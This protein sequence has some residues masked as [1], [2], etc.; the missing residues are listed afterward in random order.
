MLYRTLLIGLGGTGIDVLRKFKNHYVKFY[1]RDQKYIRLLGI[2]T[3]EQMDSGDEMLSQQEFL[4]LGNPRISAKMVLEHRN[5]PSFD[6]LDPELPAFTIASGAGMKRL[7]GHIAYFWRGTD[8]VQRLGEVKKKLYSP[9]LAKE[10]AGIE[11]GGRTRVFI[12][13]SVCGGTGTSMFLNV[14]YLVGQIFGLNAVR[15]GVLFLPSTFTQLQTNPSTFRWMQ[16]NGYAALQELNY[17]M[18]NT[19]DAKRL[20]A[21]GLNPDCEID[22][23]PGPFDL[24]FLQG[25]VDEQGNVLG[26]SQDLYTRTAQFLFSCTAFPNMSGKVIQYFAQNIPQSYAAFGS[27]SI[28]L[29]RAQFVERYVRSMGREI[30]ADLFS[31]PGANSTDDIRTALAGS[32]IEALKDG[33]AAGAVALVEAKLDQ[34]V[35]VHGQPSSQQD[36]STY[37]NNEFQRWTGIKQ[38]ITFE[39][40]SR[41]GS[42]SQHIAA[43][44]TDEAGLRARFEA[45]VIDSLAVL[46]R[47][48]VSEIDGIIA[49]QG[50]KPAVGESDIDVFNRFRKSG[51][52]P[53][54]NA[55]GRFNEFRSAL[56][57]SAREYAAREWRNEI[58]TALGQVRAQ[59]QSTLSGY[60]RILDQSE[61][62]LGEFEVR[63][64]AYL[65]DYR[66]QAKEDSFNGSDEYVAFRGQYETERLGL[67]QKC[68]ANLPF[69]RILDT[70]K[71]FA[72]DT[73][74]ENVHTQTSE[75][76]RDH[77]AQSQ[78][79]N[80]DALRSAFREA[81]V[82]LQLSPSPNL[83]ASASNWCFAPADDR[84][85]DQLAAAMNEVYGATAAIESVGPIEESFV[86]FM[87]IKGN[88]ELKDVAEIKTMKAA[89]DEFRKGKDGF[90]LD[91]PNHRRVDIVRGNQPFEEAK[92][93]SLAV[94]LGALEPFGVNFELFGKKL[95]HADESDP[96]KRRREAYERL[97]DPDLQKKIRQFRDSKIKELKNR[98]YAQFLRGRIDA[99]Y[100]GTDA[101]G[102][103]GKLFKAERE[104]LER[105][106]ADLGVPGFMP[107]SSI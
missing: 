54:S 76:V 71:G 7:L 44:L 78:L 27:F 51:I 6:W 36:A 98:G 35:F 99:E 106:L 41:A 102:E 79:L 67:L 93:F 48:A 14:S 1:D 46:Y 17:Y 87:R 85:R 90:F 21:P 73:F 75:Y 9:E 23:E 24:C 56:Q 96:V 55:I 104:A 92:W 58:R 103:Y 65:S 88:F 57:T 80:Q 10:F 77:I 20:K 40:R 72:L 68:R 52:L 61:A 84:L 95:L 4:H 3:A 63:A 91:V 60:M 100:G 64:E 49:Q 107:T 2:D 11:D 13:S 66:A 42:A 47:A 70:T 39:L 45:G 74:I 28:R 18:Q 30:L 31:K 26:N 50:S 43:A 82:N 37:I 94:A 33:S 69:S 59:L 105:E 53:F 34:D 62:I 97:S 86:S 16:A 8:I 83:Q 25:G 89:Y 38:Q 32:N 29:P 81:W 5:T 19:F 12:V 22:I 101:V 15:L